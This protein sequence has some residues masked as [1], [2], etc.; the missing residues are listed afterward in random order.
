MPLDIIRTAGAVAAKLHYLKRGA[1]KP[2]RD[3]P[4]RHLMFRQRGHRHQTRGIVQAGDKT[5]IGA[6][7]R[8]SGGLHLQ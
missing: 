1:E 8:P 5:V 2:T 4:S 6:A 3:V 7:R